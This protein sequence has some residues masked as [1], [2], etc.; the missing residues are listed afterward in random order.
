[1][2]HQLVALLRGGIER[3]GI[4]HLV[5]RGVRH[6]LVAA[7]DRGGRGI[8]QMLDFVVTAGLQDIVESDKVALNVRVGIGDAV[9]DSSLSGKIHDNGNLVFRED[10]LHCVFVSDGGVDKSPVTMQSLYFFQTLILDVDIVVVGCRI[11]TDN[12][13]VIDIMEESL[14]EVTTD[15][16]GSARHEDGFALEIYV[17]LYHVFCLCL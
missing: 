15:K 8:D 16:A 9:A 7:I 12:L 3:Y 4:V 1:M 13:D 11:D 5:V 2:R 14:D 10:F 6:L 17:I